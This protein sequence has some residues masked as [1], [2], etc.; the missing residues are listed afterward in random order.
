MKKAALATLICTLV[1][2]AAAPGTGAA[3]LSTP[4][5]EAAQSP[6]KFKVT[7]RLVLLNVLVHDHG[8]HPIGGLSKTDF[9]VTDAGRPE[10]IS[11]FSVN[12]FTHAST[13]TPPDR[14][15]PPNVVTNWPTG[16]VG[17]PVGVTVV[18][19]DKYNTKLMDQARVKRQLIQFLSKVLPEE[20]QVAIY[21]LNSKGFAIVHDFTNNAASLKTAMEKEEPQSSHELEGAAFD[22]ANTGKD[23][24][25]AMLDESN[26]IMSNFFTQDRI[27]N[28]CAALKSVADRLSGIPGR[29]NLIWITG[30]VPMELRTRGLEGHSLGEMKPTLDQGEQYFASYVEKAGQALNNA[31]VAVYPVDAGGVVTA[32]F[33][34]ASRSFP[35]DPG[36]H[37]LPSMPEFYVDNHNTMTMEYLADLTGGKAFHDTNDVAKAVRNAIDDSSV[38]YTLGYYVTASEW[39]N[40][41][42]KIKVTVRRS[43]MQVRTKKEYLAQDKPTP[44]S[45]QLE[46]VLKEAIW[47]PLDST[48][49]AIIARIDPSPVLPNASRFSFAIDAAEIDFRQE[50]ETYLGEM[51]LLFFQEHQGGERA[52]GLKKTV[53]I[54]LTPERYKVMQQSGLTLGDDLRILPDTVAVRVI[55]VDRSS[56]ATG[57]I[58]V[59]VR[60]EDKSGATVVPSAG[61]TAPH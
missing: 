54:A 13:G 49:L 21:A 39:N 14:T 35:P 24:V 61:Q 3:R 42:H 11:L 20:D 47:S 28:T 50:Q 16:R 27:V 31:N 15:L 2:L 17:A 52:A 18:L 7:T 44:T 1:L 23:Q 4:P 43:G 8:G 12:Q 36:R 6:A 41:H 40:K 30:S 29:K 53:K 22:R 32:S 9:E 25:D 45:V 26:T 60:P 57:S 55:V 46:E 58:T 33:T 19:I 34:D 10:T 5:E 37:N 59:R 51:D 38:S 56:G 48:R